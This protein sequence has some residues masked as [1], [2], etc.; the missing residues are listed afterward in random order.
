MTPK[1]GEAPYATYEK[2]FPTQTDDLENFFQTWLF[3]GLLSE[4]LAELFNY[5]SFVS[6]SERDGSPVVSTK[7]LQSLTEQRFEMIKTLDRPRQR[8]IYLHAVQCIHL[9]VTILPVAAPDFN[10][11]VKN[12]I[13][14]LAEFL[15]SAIDKAHRSTFS[16]AVLC[17]KPSTRCFYTEEMKAAM[18]AANWCPNDITWITDKFESTQLL[19]FLSK[20][21]KPPGLSN[22]RNC[23]EKVCLA[24]SMSLSQ[25]MT[26]HCEA[27]TDEHRCEE[28]SVDHRPVVDILRSG[29]IPLLRIDLKENEPSKVSVEVFSSGADTAPYVAVSHVWADGLG[30]PSA[31]SLPHC[32]LARLG[33]MLDPFSETGKRPLVWLDTL[34]CP[35]NPE[36]KTLALLQMRR[37]YAEASKTLILDSSMYN[38]NGQSLSTAELQARIL[39][40]GWMRR[41]WTL[42]ESAL[43]REPWVQFKDGPL[44][45]MTMFNRLKEQ[46]DKNLSHRRLVQDMWSV[47][48][49]LALGQYYSPEN[50]RELWLLDQALSHRN[51]TFAIDEAPC[52][53]TLMDLEVS[54]ILPLS[55]ED[56]M[57]K[58]WDLLAAANKGSLP[59]NM[60]FLG[61]PKLNRR[62]H[63]WAP[64]TL[65]PSS[66]RFH[67][68]QTRSLR[69][70][71]Q[72]AKSTPEGLMA[73]YPSYRFCP[74]SGSSPSPIWNMLSEI[75]QVR[76]IFKDR[77]RGIWCQI[78][79]KS[80]STQLGTNKSPS[81]F[82]QTPYVDLVGQNDLAVILAEEPSD[83]PYTSLGIP[84]Q[85]GIL[86][87]VTEEK[88]NVLYATLGEGVVLAALSP[89]E[90]IVYDA[91]EW[92]M[93][94]LR[95]W[96]LND[97]EGLGT[98]ERMSKERI[99]KL[100]DKCK[101]MTSELLAKK[102]LLEDAVLE[103]L[104]EGGQGWHLWAVVA[105]WFDHVGEGWR[106]EGGQ[107]WCVD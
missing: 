64:S 4:L 6:E 97:S 20:M 23:T 66:E 43:A 31:N 22:H 14:S 41:L 36:A 59:R 104:G 40:S 80:T 95:K 29:A 24:H 15:G 77:T 98:A 49:T 67:T 82:T 92:L 84:C 100:K 96:E 56:R 42:Q 60:I 63:R 51:T 7:R 53:A 10:S 25:H 81:E 57:W 38:Y 90:V 52:I 45:L 62:G 103:M 87:T 3:F 68:E 5:E 12:S 71:G 74:Y 21:K 102:P 54:E 37:T 88:T 79:Y 11:V 58:V 101:E 72:Q 47:S 26:R 106:V 33:N 99:G 34:C 8:G 1:V 83:K 65:L 91:A 28:I 78:Y 18:V 2:L 44:S 16:D 27:C 75:P 61:G 13:T 48:K 76:F 73:N 39:T 85:E 35:V 107:M 70:H 94:E 46:H 93:L 89:Q 32:Q 55:G 30:N 69:W 50:G 17:W 105:G 86:V 19:Y 9:T